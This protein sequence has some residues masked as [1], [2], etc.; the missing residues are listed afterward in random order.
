MAHSIDAIKK[1]MLEDADFADLAAE[2]VSIVLECNG[3]IRTEGTLERLERILSNEKN[4][5]NL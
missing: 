1:R 3:N 5:H 4:N 2:I